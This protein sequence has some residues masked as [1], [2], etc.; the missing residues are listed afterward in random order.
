MP[1]HFRQFQTSCLSSSSVPAPLQNEMSPNRWDCNF[2][3][4]ARPSN[5]SACPFQQFMKVTDIL[6]GCLLNCLSGHGTGFIHLCSAQNILCRFSY[7]L[8][9]ERLWKRQPPSRKR[10]FFDGCFICVLTIFIHA[11][12]SCLLVGLKMYALS[13]RLG[14]SY[15]V[16]SLTCIFCLT[17]VQYTH[18]RFWFNFINIQ[19]LLFQ[20]GK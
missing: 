18:S 3:D 19:T 7:P 8:L 11:S 2:H 14:I 1:C 4:N 5:F 20:S 9:L 15:L 13:L 6:P 16:T 12:F 17:P 10:H